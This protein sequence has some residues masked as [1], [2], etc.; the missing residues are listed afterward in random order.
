MK[1]VADCIGA[2]V[3]NRRI[4]NLSQFRFSLTSQLVLDIPNLNSSHTHMWVGVFVY[5]E[6]TLFFVTVKMYKT[7]C[8]STAHSM[9]GRKGGLKF[10]QVLITEAEKFPFPLIGDLFSCCLLVPVNNE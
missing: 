3:D 7:P 2:L 5:A 8:T 9:Y 4:L 10:S 6:Q 1:E